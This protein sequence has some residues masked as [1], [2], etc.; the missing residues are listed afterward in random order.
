MT[1]I[2]NIIGADHKIL[3]LGGDAKLDSDVEN[4]RNCVGIPNGFVYQDILRNRT[5]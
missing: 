1:D 4:A 3:R 2:Q 5:V